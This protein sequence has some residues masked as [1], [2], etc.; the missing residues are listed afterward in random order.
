[1]LIKN[2]PGNGGPLRVARRAT[3][4]RA[5]AAPETRLL[6]DWRSLDAYVLL[7]DPG[8]GKSVAFEIETK[9][10]DGLLIPPRGIIDGIASN[11]IGDGI[12]FI[13][14]LDEVR[15]GAS[16]VRTPFGAIRKWLN[17]TGRPRFRLS[18][19]EADWLGESDLN[20]LNSVA[21]GGLVEVLHLDPFDRDDV[22]EVLRYRVA[23]V[24]DPDEFWRKAEQFGLTDLFGNPLLLDL[25]IRA[26]SGAGK[27]PST[28]Q[29]I[30]E[31]ACR[32]LA[33]ELNQEHLAAKRLQPGAVDRLL[34]DAGLLCAVLLLSNSQA[35]SEALDNST[36]TVILSTLPATFPVG[37]ARAALA[38]KVFTTV[39][40]RAKP[41][42]RS[43]AE[44]LAAKELAKRIEEG[45]PVGRLLALMQGFDGRP[46]EPLRGLFAWLTVHH[47]RDRL[48][49]IRLDPLG[50]VLNGDVASFSFD[51]RLELLRALSD[52]ARQDRHFRRNAWV[53]HP[54][55][56]LATADMASSFAEWLSNP[57]RSAENLA[58]LDC[59][60]DA[61]T[62]G[63][64]MFALAPALEKWVE[65][66]D[67][68]I[69]IRLSAYAAWKHNAGFDA[70]KA[71]EWLEK[72]M[73]GAL[74][75]NDGQLADALLSDLYPKHLGPGEVLKFM[76]PRAID[77]LLP[78]YSSFWRHQLLR[79]TS[80]QQLVALADAWVDAKVTSTNEGQD[81]FTREIGGELLV[82]VLAHS[83]QIVP[84]ERLHAWLGIGLDTY[85]SSMLI[86]DG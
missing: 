77:H 35:I 47:G 12:V 60:Y 73:R 37:D 48:R 70:A 74:A 8:A 86:D 81:F 7:G 59:V 21:N 51:E 64:P 80:P 55:G 46:V 40:G 49:M 32:Q 11:L 31:L 38:S 68:L 36:D 30:Y 25:T 84:I 71:L 5:G 52:E 20:A 4:H 50:V 58:F 22:R 54:F 75:D 33:T 45:L 76:R 27:W 79:R 18:C 67:A 29:E 63:Q 15:A 42:H 56:A 61:L 62:H 39:A 57:D 34:N 66:A 72:M 19:R 14:G 53:S 13:D 3:L 85:G 9:A 1:M 17:D 65:D 23:E 28:R 6:A 44:Y 10:C 41:M 78:E 24:P 43:I 83:G 2:L 26:V 16:D 69:G 82:A